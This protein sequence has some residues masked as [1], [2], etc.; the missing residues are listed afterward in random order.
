M[1]FGFILNLLGYNHFFTLI[2]MVFFY[3]FKSTEVCVFLIK[4]SN[5]LFPFQNG[6]SAIFH[7]R[8][9]ISDQFVDDANQNK[10]LV[11]NY[12]NYV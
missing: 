4:S 10:Q 2:L 5:K 1:K 11:L 7:G 3:F 9:L 6:P 12:Q 8:S